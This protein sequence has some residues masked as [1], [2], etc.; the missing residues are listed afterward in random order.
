MPAKKN[1]KGKKNGG[2]SSVTTPTP[3][4]TITSS[5]RAPADLSI[6]T[7]V[8][9]SLTK[10]SPRTPESKIPVLATPTLP[11]F[12][13]KLQKSP[14]SAAAKGKVA[15]PASTNK[16]AAGKVYAPLGLGELS[17]KPLT[18]ASTE[19]EKDLSGKNI[20]SSLFGKPT[21]LG[22]D[23]APQQPIQVFMA[24]VDNGADGE[25]EEKHS[26]KHPFSNSNRSMYT[27]TH[28]PRQRWTIIVSS[29]SDQ[30]PIIVSSTANHQPI[31]IAWKLKPS[32]STPY[33]QSLRASL[34]GYNC[35]SR[36]APDNGRRRR[37]SHST[38][39]PNRRTH[40]TL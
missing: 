27:N 12:S 29:T 14:T 4:D 16:S 39:H 23:F 3:G 24:D 21:R 37:C 17:P 5:S 36:R 7:A 8:E 38:P 22:D 10:T 35:S 25:D 34:P 40:S 9:I 28:S 15:V 32:S 11:N 1:K 30:R 33:I 20:F 26:S 31:I 19:K 13:K 2:R 6:E 18:F